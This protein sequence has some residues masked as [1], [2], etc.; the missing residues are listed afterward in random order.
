MTTLDAIQTN[1]VMKAIQPNGFA[2]CKRLAFSE[3]KVAAEDS[4]L[5]YYGGL[6]YD[7][8]NLD[9]QTKTFAA[10]DYRRGDGSNV[11][12]LAAVCAQAMKGQEVSF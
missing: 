8:K 10:W 7:G 11:G 5:L 2:Y 12:R 9:I 3:S 4:N 6:E 1:A